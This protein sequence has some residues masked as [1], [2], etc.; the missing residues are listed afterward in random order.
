MLPTTLLPHL[1]PIAAK[2]YL[3]LLSLQDKNAR[4]VRAH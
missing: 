1:S 4:T 2:L 3:T